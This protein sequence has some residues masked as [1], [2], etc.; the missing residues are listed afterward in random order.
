V[1]VEEAGG[2]VVA[3]ADACP[4]PDRGKPRGSG[5]QDEAATGIGVP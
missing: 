2:G 5:A 4:R 1:E 3:L